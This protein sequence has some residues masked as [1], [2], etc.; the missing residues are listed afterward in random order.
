MSRP[1]PF[2]RGVLQD[3]FAMVSM[4]AGFAGLT[5]VCVGMAGS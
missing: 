4:L 3:V 2:W 5:L 1:T